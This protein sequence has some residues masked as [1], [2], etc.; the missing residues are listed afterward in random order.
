MRRTDTEYNAGP[1]PRVKCG[2]VA[3]TV[4]CAGAL[5]KEAMCADSDYY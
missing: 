5:S 3:Q 4:Y 2:T 1:M